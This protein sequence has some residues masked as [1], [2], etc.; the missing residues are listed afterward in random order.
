[1][2]VKDLFFFVCSKI[3]DEED[4]SLIKFMRMTLNDN[5]IKRKEHLLLE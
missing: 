1:L 4:A 3:I 2:V 5:V